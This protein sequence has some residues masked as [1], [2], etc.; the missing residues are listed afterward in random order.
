MNILSIRGVAFLAFLLLFSCAGGRI[1]KD[2]ELANSRGTLAAYEEFL[3]KYPDSN[4]TV[5]VT[6]RIQTLR[7]IKERE[8]ALLKERI[9]DKKAQLDTLNRARLRQLAGYTIGKT[10]FSDFMAGGWNSKDP[11]E[12]KLGVVGVMYDDIDA[13]ARR[14]FRSRNEVDIILGFTYRSLG[15]ESE[16]NATSPIFAF[17]RNALDGELSRMRGNDRGIRS[18]VLPMMTPKDGKLLTVKEW[19]ERAKKPVAMEP[20]FENTAVVTFEQNSK[21]L[22]R[23]DLS[24]IRDVEIPFP[25]DPDEIVKECTMDYAWLAKVAGK[26]ERVPPPRPEEIAEAF[27][28]QGLR[29]I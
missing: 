1:H 20:F 11:L 14:D 28:G 2:Y 8:E 29:E 18:N 10:I 25:T 22:K 7:E 16:T 21:I 26:S 17:R 6:K 15:R 23:I 27:S 4:Y 9:S 3:Q 19:K 5:N 24:G 13:Q 12:G